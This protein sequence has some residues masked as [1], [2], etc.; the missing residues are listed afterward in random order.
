LFVTIVARL[1]ET[2]QL[3]EPEFHFIAVMSLDVVGDHC[4]LDNAMA[5]AFGAKRL[6]N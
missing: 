4:G 1:A 2:L 6:E 5:K 3:A